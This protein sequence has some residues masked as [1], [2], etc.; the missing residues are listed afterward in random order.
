MRRAEAALDRLNPRVLLGVALFGSGAL[1]L[2]LLSNLTFFGD[3]WDPLLYR[4][5]F[6][7]DVLL[8]PHAEHILLAPTLIYKGIQATIG[9]ESLVPYAVISTIS[10]LASAV[11]LFF[12]LR[13]RVGD[14]L[15]F[16][17]LLPV[18]FMGTAWEVLLWPFEVSFTASMAT[19]IGALLALERDE[20]RGDAVACG[21][22]V[23]SLTFSEL[24]IPFVLGAAVWMVLARA[25][26]SRAYVL[27]VPLVLYAAWYVGWGHEAQTHVSA[28][29][30]FH[31]PKYVLAGLAST[32][33]SLLGAPNKVS[34]W[35]GLPL[36]L[37]LVVVA[38]AR[39]RSTKPLPGSFWSALAILLAFWFLDAINE[40]PGRGPNASR[41]QYVGAFLLLMVL[42]ELADGIRLR[43]AVLPAVLGVASLAVITNLVVLGYYYN[44]LSDWATRARG[45]LAAFQIGGASADPNFV[46]DAA[47]TDIASLNSL[48]VGLYLSAIKAF[49]SP[50]YGASE[51]ANAPEEARVAAD[52]LLA[53]A[54]GLRLVPVDR[55]PPPGGP[56]PRL[57]GASGRAALPQGSCLT[58]SGADGP[59]APVALPRPGVTVTAPPDSVETVE[60]RR[61]ASSFPIRYE[62]RGAGVLL[63]RTDSS[64]RPWQLRALGPGSTRI[65]GIG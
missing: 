63:I 12:Y 22:L 39:I 65:C 6:N 42:A 47:N 38:V 50:A 10:F 18:L 2:I 52:Q 24:A 53:D 58:I 51:L 25:N 23:V 5:G 13:R 17:A 45:A 62:L 59:S 46:T 44:R 30:L 32:V 7:L 11:A 31:S 19:G 3:D 37:L 34:I 8:R 16:A 41:Y 14:W 56:P 21:L 35:V 55:P 54:E 28:H 1:L 48:Q 57:V 36:L 29:N 64:P 26:W 4:R 27:V 33:G 43:R 40:I 15:A 60:L 61:F 20:G 49:G 9:M